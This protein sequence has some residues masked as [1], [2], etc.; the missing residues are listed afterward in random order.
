M[1][2]L[3]TD[4]EAE[5]LEEEIQDQIEEIEAEAVDEDGNPEEKSSS[6]QVNEYLDKYQRLLADFNNY[7]R[8]EEKSK[9]DFKSFA[10]SSLIEKL[11]PVLDNFDRALKDCNE[12]DSFVKGIIMTRN[13]LWKVLEN[14]GL[15]E[16][17]SDNEEFNPNLHQAFMTEESDEVEENHIIETFQKGYKLKDKVIRPSMVKVSK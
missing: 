8:R 9:A 17:P 12:E 11:L 16:I 1:D 4:S 2:N 7:K 10:T 13:E 14:E 5:N 15:S 6:D 3:E